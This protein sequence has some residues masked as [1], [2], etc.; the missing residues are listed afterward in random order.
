MQGVNGNNRKFHNIYSRRWRS[1]EIQRKE[2]FSYYWG[3]QPYSFVLIKNILVNE[4]T[5][6]MVTSCNMPNN[7]YTNNLLSFSNVFKNKVSIIYFLFSPWKKI[8]KKWHHLWWRFQQ[9]SP[10]SCCLDISTECQLGSAAGAR[11]QTHTRIHTY[12]L[13]RMGSLKRFK[14]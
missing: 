11:K 1:V 6:T 13:T 2:L 7:L 9:Q 4:Y 12:A 14:I 10:K 8:A 5:K 3:T